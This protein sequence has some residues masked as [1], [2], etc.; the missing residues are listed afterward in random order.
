MSIVVIFD[1]MSE[2]LEQE[3]LNAIAMKIKD[4]RIEAGFSGHRQ[5]A[6][7]YDMQAKQYWRIESGKNF[8]MLTFLRILEIHKITLEE[9]FKG[10]E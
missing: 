8:T 5:F 9:F 3:R 1:F 10:L 7:E 4:L 2:S 6:D